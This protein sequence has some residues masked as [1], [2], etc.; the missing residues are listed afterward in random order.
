MMYGKV[1]VC[2]ECRLGSKFN[3]YD[4]TNNVVRGTR[5][6]PSIVGGVIQALAA[7]Y[8]EKDRQGST[9]DTFLDEE[10]GPP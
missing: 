7:M 2:H 3:V 1:D 6:P 10:I 4:L 5:L 8:L 9:L